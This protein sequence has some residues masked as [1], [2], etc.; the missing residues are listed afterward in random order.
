LKAC[1][2]KSSETYVYALAD[3][4]TDVYASV[5]YVTYAHSSEDYDTYVYAF[6]T[7]K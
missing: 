4:A 1:G 5:D 3:Y 2:S 7:I 6:V